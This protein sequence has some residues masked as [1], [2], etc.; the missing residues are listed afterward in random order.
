MPL[1]ATRETPLAARR[2][3]TARWTRPAKSD[4]RSSLRRLPPVMPNIRAHSSPMPLLLRTLKL[5]A[6]TVLAALLFPALASSAGLDSGNVCPNSSARVV[7]ELASDR[8]DACAG[9]ADAIAFFARL[10]L[11]ATEALSIEITTQLPKEAGPTGAGC[12]IEQ[13]KRIYMLPFAK[14]RKQKTWFG[15]R[16]DRRMYR[17]LATHEA[18]HALTA[19]HFS[20]PR[21]TIQAKE[22]IAYVA[23]FST[24]ETGLRSKALRATPGTGFTGEERITPLLH[25]FDPMR[26]GA[27]SY[28]HF[29]KPDVGLP[30][31]KSVLEGKALVD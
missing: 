5:K 3:L 4:A 15:V 23:M 13:R 11:E 17:S 26:F 24:M 18:A 9:V 22:Y 6:A 28:R 14:F 16:I 1:L 30:F 31:I 19:C 2:G 8:H 27:E 29:I 21:P 25:M 20:V 7:A 10:G 12:F